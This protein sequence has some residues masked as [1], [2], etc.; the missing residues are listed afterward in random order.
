MRTSPPS[1]GLVALWWPLVA[2]AR[3]GEPALGTEAE[4]A[5]RGDGPGALPGPRLQAPSVG[6]RV[7]RPGRRLAPTAPWPSGRPLPRP[8]RSGRLLAQQR[9]VGGAVQDRPQRADVRLAF[10]VA[11]H[12]FARL[13]AGAD[14]T[15]RGVSRLAQTPLFAGETARGGCN[16]SC[17]R[18]AAVMA[19]RPGGSESRVRPVAAGSGSSPRAGSLPPR[20]KWAAA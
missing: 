19:G 18:G 14:G 4:L 13:T 6:M 17:I 7:P 1:G 15:G 20:A 11:E 8:S 3:R 5:S 9:E 16:R 2:L 12:V 10:P